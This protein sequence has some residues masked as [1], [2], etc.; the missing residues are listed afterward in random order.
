M[1]DDAMFKDKVQVESVVRTVDAEKL[2]LGLELLTLL[3]VLC[4]LQFRSVG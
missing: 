4:A 3:A 1:I 2:P